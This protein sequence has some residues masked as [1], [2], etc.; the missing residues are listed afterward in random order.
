MAPGE[1]GY[2]IPDDLAILLQGLGFGF[3]GWYPGSGGYYA[4][5][6]TDIGWIEEQGYDVGFG[7]YINSTQSGE[8]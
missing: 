3:E 1:K 5:L 4:P 8:I 7:I 6:N 2:F